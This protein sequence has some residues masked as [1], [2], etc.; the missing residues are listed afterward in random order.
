MNLFYAQVEEIKDQFEGLSPN[1]R[2]V[3]AREKN[4]DKI[5]VE[6]ETKV[7]LATES[8]R[9]KLKSQIKDTI[10][11]SMQVELKNPNTIPKSQGEKL[12]RID[13]RRITPS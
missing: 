13:D 4:M 1:Y 6:V 8:L 11:L 9:N 2:L 7:G 12:S 10:G 3:V 5:C